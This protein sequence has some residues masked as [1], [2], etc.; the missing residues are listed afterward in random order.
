MT[1][2]SDQAFYVRDFPA[3]CTWMRHLVGK[4]QDLGRDSTG[5]SSPYFKITAETL[6][7]KS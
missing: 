1:T 6:Q 4:C 3:H 5:N 7:S 2:K